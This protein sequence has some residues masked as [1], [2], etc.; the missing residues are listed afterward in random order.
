MPQQPRRARKT[1]GKSVSRS[2]REQTKASFADIA[3]TRGS[4]ALLRY[5]EIFS[6]QSRAKSFLEPQRAAAVARLRASQRSRAAVTHK[7]KWS[8]CYFFPAVVIGWQCCSIRDGTA[9]MSPSTQARRAAMAKK[10]KTK[11]AAKKAPKKTAKRKK[12]KK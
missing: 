2:A 6:A 9:P 11:A 7:I 12:A 3:E 1:T 8:H 5:D 4:S 10:R